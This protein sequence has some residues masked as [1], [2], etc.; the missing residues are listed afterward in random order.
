MPREMLFKS[1]TPL[2]DKEEEE[3]IMNEANLFDLL[4]EQP[5]TTPETPSVLFHPKPFKK[6]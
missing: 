3:K 2:F 4:S 5:S 1:S 6:L